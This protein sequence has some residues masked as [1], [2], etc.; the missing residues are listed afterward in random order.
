[1]QAEPC[2]IIGSA[3]QRRHLHPPCRGSDQLYPRTHS[4]LYHQ[5]PAVPIDSWPNREYLYRCYCYPCI[6]QIGRGFSCI[7]GGCC[8]H[9]TVDIYVSTS[10]VPASC[11]VA[12]PHAPQRN[13]AS[14]VGCR[15]GVGRGQLRIP[16]PTSWH[17]QP[18]HVTRAHAPNDSTAHGWLDSKRADPEP[19]TG[20]DREHTSILEMV[21]QP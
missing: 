15:H 18:P 16:T 14:S 17:Y 5:A 21:D 3:P 7:A 2:V 8:I 20:A 12:A 4:L 13:I 1:M 9:F 19:V 11:L 6:H 10:I